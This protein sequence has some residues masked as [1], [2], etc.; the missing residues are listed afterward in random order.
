MR[1]LNDPE[2]SVPELAKPELKLFEFSAP[3]L[4]LP[5]LK[6][7]ALVWPRITDTRLEPGARIIHTRA[8]QA[9]A[10]VPEAGATRWQS[11]RG[12][13]N[14]IPPSPTDGRRRLL[15]GEW[16]QESGN[17]EQSE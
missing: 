11:G 13:H 10:R 12:Q 9:R 8:T 14:S 17:P 4:K 6:R 1:L 5:V 3:A 16:Y 7:P 15:V 2:L